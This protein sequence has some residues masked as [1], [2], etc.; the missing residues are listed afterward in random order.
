MV[1][2]RLLRS[3]EFGCDNGPPVNQKCAFAPEF[4]VRPLSLKKYDDEAMV[5]ER[6]PLMGT[7]LHPHITG[8]DNLST[9]I[10]KSLQPRHVIPRSIIIIASF[11]RVVGRRLDYEASRYFSELPSLAKVCKTFTTPMGTFWSN[12]TFKQPQ[13]GSPRI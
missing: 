2:R 10:R 1:E 11:G 4:P 8:Y 3:F 9:I 6:Q 12:A 5:N 7:A 13:R